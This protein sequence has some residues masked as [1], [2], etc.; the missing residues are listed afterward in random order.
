M[1]LSPLVPI[2]FDLVACTDKLF[3][4]SAKFVAHFVSPVNQQIKEILE[5]L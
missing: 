4:S 5:S 1:L 3:R 2:I